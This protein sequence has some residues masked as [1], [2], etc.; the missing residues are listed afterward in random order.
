VLNI[1]IKL[2]PKKLTNP[3]ADI[4]YKLPEYLQDATNDLVKDDGYDYLDDG[5][6]VL[7]LVGDEESAVEI[8]LRTLRN[9][10]F[11]GND[12]MSMVVIGVDVGPGFTVVHPPDFQGDF[13]FE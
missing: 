12:L 1:V 6:L 13:T 5:S 9:G 10:P 2:D 11:L 7:F 8:I 3:D 4:R